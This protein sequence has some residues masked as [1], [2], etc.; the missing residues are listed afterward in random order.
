M[1]FYFFNNFYIFLILNLEID[2]N[3]RQ[4]L[5]IDIMHGE[6]NGI[7]SLPIKIP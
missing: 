7:L 2:R 6:L 5:L 3:A 4:H 1:H